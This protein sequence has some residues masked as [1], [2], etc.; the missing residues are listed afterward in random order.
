VRILSECPIW[1]TIAVM[2][3]SSRRRHKREATFLESVQELLESLSSEIKEVKQCIKELQVAPTSYA[4]TLP[5]NDF[6]GSWDDWSAWYSLGFDETFSCDGG[7]P[8]CSPEATASP[9]ADIQVLPRETLLA[10][11]HVS[12]VPLASQRSKFNH[13]DDIVDALFCRAGSFASLPAALPKRSGPERGNIEHE[14][15]NVPVCTGDDKAPEELVET[16]TDSRTHRDGVSKLLLWRPSEKTIFMNSMLQDELLAEAATTIQ[17]WFRGTCYREWEHSDENQSVSSE[18]ADAS[19]ARDSATN[20]DGD[21]PH[22]DNSVEAVSIRRAF[23][24]ST[25]STN[26]GVAA[27]DSDECWTLSEILIWVSETLNESW[28]KMIGH[29]A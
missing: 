20:G 14:V 15:P 9:A 23:M 8:V 24:V 18:S 2:P 28:I 3:G 10:Y 21:H 19:L 29:P 5:Y 11:Q 1:L 4:S 7:A 27:P 13:D 6:V 17:R 26:P 25:A 16:I 12:D 22:D